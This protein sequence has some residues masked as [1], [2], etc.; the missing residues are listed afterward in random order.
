MMIH[1]KIPL[2][3]MA[4][5]VV[6]V[7]SACAQ[8]DNRLLG[9]VTFRDEKVTAL[10]MHSDSKHIVV[11]YSNGTINIFEPKP[12]RT[13]SIES[14]P[15]HNKNV[16]AAAFSADNKWVATAGTD[17]LV[18]LWETYVIAK[19][20]EDCENRK[21]GAVKP[22]IPGPKKVF[23]AQSGM[24]TGVAFSP[25]GKQIATSGSDGSIK[26]WNTETTKLAF[27]IAAHKGPVNAVVFSPDGTKIASA[28]ADKIAR[29]WK[30]AASS[31]AIHALTGHDGPVTS[32]D[33]S[34]DSKLLAT[35]SGAPKKGGQAR[36]YDMETGKLSYSLEP[37]DD[38]VTTVSFHPKLPRL[39][40]GGKDK[41]IRV[42]NLE[43][44][45]ILYADGHANELIR[46]VFTGDGGRLGTICADEV[47]YWN[48]S[49]NRK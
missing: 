26:V 36:V 9:R 6:A 11:G 3:T 17:G 43:T 5:F 21:E 24:V 30:A 1:S 8:D 13:I 31:K 41:K 48:G 20:Q 49:P 22:P 27:T 46:V 37:L 14:I 47:K 7:A 34:A 4:S 19:F 39:A 18:K 23:G 25:N 28:G 38:T 44:Q 32:V 10:A 42:W 29:V 33:F 45:K 35:G 2:L 40:T 15:A 12:G 16:S